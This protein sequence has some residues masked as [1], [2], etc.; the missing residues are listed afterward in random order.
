[1]AESF[2]EDMF[3]GKLAEE[4]VRGGLEAMYQRGE[5]IE[6]IVSA[7]R[8]MI[9]RMNRISPDVGETQLLDIVGTGGDGKGSLNISTI[10]AFVAAGAGCNVAKHW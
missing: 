3:E 6:E 10:S 7:A 5:T 4:A 1:M 2:F 9:K 8:A